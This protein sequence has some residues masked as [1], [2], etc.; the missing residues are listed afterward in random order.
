ML[1]YIKQKLPFS[2][3]VIYSNGDLLTE[4]KFNQIKNYIH[5]IY[6]SKGVYA[7][8]TLIFKKG[9]YTPLNWTYPDYADAE[10]IALFN[11]I[12]G[13]YMEQLKDMKRLD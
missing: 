11:G 13:K 1:K 5:R 7:D 2:K 9:T 12:R 6:L 8:L 3:I 10:M 4:K